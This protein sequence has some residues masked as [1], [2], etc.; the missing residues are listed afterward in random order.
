MKCRQNLANRKLL[1]RRVG[2]KREYRE[3]SSTKIL[4]VLKFQNLHKKEFRAHF[5]KEDLLNKRTE[6]ILEKKFS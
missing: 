6:Q 3:I 1:K 4:W 2:T 5:Y